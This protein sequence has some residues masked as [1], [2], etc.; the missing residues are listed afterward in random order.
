MKNIPYSRQYISKKDIASVSKSLK[1]NLITS[2]NNTEL[3][4]K[5]LSTYCKSR[6]AS[7]VSSATAALHLACL[8]LG[9]KNNDIVWCSANSFVA[10]SNAALYCGAKIDFIDIN[11]DDY[12][13]SEKNLK[14]KL[15]KTDKKK[16]PKIVIVTHMGGIPSNLEAIHKLSKKYNFIIIEDAS[17]A[18][19]SS[20]K[21]KRIGS[22]EFSSICIFSFHPIKTITTGEGGACLTNDFEIDKKIKQLRS[23]G[24]IRNLNKKN[25]NKFYYEQIDLGYNYRLSDINAALGISQIKR[26]N[27]ILKSRN[28]VSNF[29]RKNLKSKNIVFTVSKSDKS[30]SNH[31]FIIRLN[32][33]NLVKYQ[34]KIIDYLLKNKIL[35]N[36]HYYPIYLHP[37]YKKL[38]FKK[39][40]CPNSEAYYNSSFSIPIYEGISKKELKFI[41]TKITFVIIKY[42]K[43]N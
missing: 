2:G 29:Y 3:F 40:Y 5:K 39:G 7:L 43:L 15:E 33:H 17:H 1:E 30:S 14:N 13:I 4:E 34:K 35:V 11:L 9:V 8:A 23:H 10:T 42:L 20:Y 37:Y 19:G 28:N 36:I 41:C 6:F 25:F 12:N 18:L 38:G 26:I 24:I 32:N 27:K 31:L 16:H 21:N 22:C